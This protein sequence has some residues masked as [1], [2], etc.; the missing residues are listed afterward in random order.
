MY[1]INLSNVLTLIILSNLMHLIMLI[2]VWLFVKLSV[3]Y[4]VKYV[5]RLYLDVSSCYKADS[6]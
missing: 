6:S 2:E 3:W 4:L 5:A 1:L